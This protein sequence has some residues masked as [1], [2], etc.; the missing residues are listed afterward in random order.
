M[1]NIRPNALSLAV[2]VAISSFIIATDALASRRLQTKS[3]DFSGSEQVEFTQS[4]VIVTPTLDDNLQPIPKSFTTTYPDQTEIRAGYDIPSEGFTDVLSGIEGGVSSVDQFETDENNV[5]QKYTKVLKVGNE[6]VFRFT[7]N[8]AE[9]KLLIE[10][11]NSM[12]H[13]DSIGAV[14]AQSG[15]AWTLEPF[16]G[17]ASPDHLV[18]VLKGANERAGNLGEADNYIALAT[19]EVDKVEV[20]GRTF[21]RLVAAGDQPPELQRLGQSLFVND[22]VLLAAATSAYT[23]VHV[24]GKDIQQRALEDLLSYHNPVGYVVHVEDETQ[25]YPVPAGYPKLEVTETPGE[26]IVFHGQKQSPTDIALVQNLYGVSNWGTGYDN[27]D[28]AQVK[29]DKVKSYRY[30]IRS[31]QMTILED[32]AAKRHTGLNFVKE[33]G[34]KVYELAYFEGLQ[35]ALASAVSDGADEVEFTSEH[36]YF[37]S[38]L[39]TPTWVHIQLLRHFGFKPVL[40]NLLANGQ[41]VQDIHKALLFLTNSYVDSHIYPSDDSSGLGEDFT[42]R[43]IGDFVGQLLEMEN[44]LEKLR[45]IEA[46]LAKQSELTSRL[47]ASAA[48]GIGQNLRM[49]EL[50]QQLVDELA[51]IHGTV[52]ALVNQ[53]ETLQ[54]EADQIPLLK[55]QVH[56]ART[57]A[58]KARNAQT[59]TELGIEDWDDTQPL[60]EQARLISKKITEIFRLVAPTAQSQKQALEENLATIGA[61]LIVVPLNEDDL[62]AGQQAF[63]QQITSSEAKKAAEIKKRFT[64]IAAYLNIKDFDSNAD[65]DVQQEHLIQTLMKMV[66]QLNMEDY[67]T[68]LRKASLAAVLGI[69]LN[70]D[71]SLEDR[72]NLEL[73]VHDKLFELSKLENELE[74]IRTPG[75][76]KVMPEVF[77]TLLAVQSVFEKEHLREEN[78]VYYHRQVISEAIRIYIREARQQSDEEALAVLKSMEGI[79]SININE[80]DDKA[81]RLKR[82]L[83]RLDGGDISNHELDQMD[84]ILRWEGKR[85]DLMEDPEKDLE[86]SLVKMDLVLRSIRDWITFKVEESDQRARERQADYLIALEDKLNIDTHENPAAQE[87]GE[88]FFAKLASKLHIGFADDADLSDQKDTLRERLQELMEELEETYDDEGVKRVSNNKIA[89]QLNI[90]D[91]RDDAG[92]N[93]QKSLIREKLEQLDEEVFKVGQPDVNERIAAI[94]NELDRQMARLGSKPRYV[95]DRELATARRAVEEAESEPETANHNLDAIR[96]KQLVSLGSHTEFKDTS[97][98]DDTTLNQ[99]MK[100]YQTELG[101]SAGDEQT[102]KERVEDIINFLLECSVEIRDEIVEELRTKTN[103]DIRID[104]D[105]ASLEAAHYVIAIKDH[106]DTY[107]RD[108]TDQVDAGF[109]DKIQ[110]LIQKQAHPKAEIEASGADIERMKKVLKAA[111]EAV[112]NDGGPF[113]YTPKQAKVLDAIHTFTQQHLLKKQAL[114]AAMSLAESAVES[115]KTIPCL[116]TFDFNDEFAPIRLQALAGDELT[117]KQASWIVEVFKSLKTIFRDYPFEPA[118]HPFRNAIREAQIL[119]QRAR[120]EI[121]TASQQYDDEIRDIGSAGI[122]FVEH[123]PGDLKSFPEYFASHSAS[124]KKIMALLREG[125]ISKVELENYMKAVRGVDGYQTVAEFEHF[126]GY[127]HGVKVPEFRKVVQMLSDESAEAFMQSVFNPVTG[128]LMGPAGMKE[129]LVG[130]KDYAAAVIANYVLDDIA[131]ENGRRTAAFLINVQDTLTPYANA[132]SLSESDL[133]KAI[134][135]TLMQAHAA[136][137][138]WQ[139]KEYWVKPSAFLVQAV[140]WY[141]SS[142]KPL[143]TTHTVSQASTL[144]LSNMSLLYLLDLTNRGDYLHRMLTPFQ[145]WLERYRVDLDRTGQYAYHSGIEQISEVGGLA[146]SLGKAASSVILLKTGSALFAR[147]HNANPQRYRSIFR[148]VPEIVKSMGS[149]QGIQVPLLHRATPQKVKTLAAATAGL[150][151]GPVATVGAYAHGLISGFTYAQTF[152]LALASSLTFDFFMNDNK[153]LTQW[154]GGPLGRCLDKINRWR[155]LGETDDE[156]LQRTAIASPQGF[157]ETDEEYASRV[158]ANNTM[159]GW[160]RHENYLQ[161]RERRERTM[162]LFENGWEKYFRENV[163]KWSFSHAESIPYSYTLG[164]FYE[165]KAALTDHKDK[166][167]RN[168][169]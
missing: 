70:E 47:F 18:R 140:T 106:S 135:D 117:F 26:I 65:I 8:L 50:N 105:P 72:V 142:Y 127:K 147:Q 80:G 126:L 73:M 89:D 29:K 61:R 98:K 92:I 35:L 46:V 62:E 97:D 17:M 49:E 58:T 111:E 23:Q 83:S 112:K 161:F 3:V 155:G 2:A 11:R 45:T 86:W 25:A 101:L 95:L 123:L 30:I 59:A 6:G 93:E 128:T 115:G 82:V 31:R 107:A 55:K 134:H 42:A 28:T 57:D 41:F 108:A 66:E 68:G 164:A 110:Q 40:R 87:R 32:L 133:I 54:R 4:E 10:V 166:N 119:V 114:G 9:E 124:G 139:L 131:F 137:V 160:T 88:T 79:L 71:S 165:R 5:A 43:V 1:R 69:D 7:H 56:D 116:K 99:A 53:I 16:T 34:D 121:K 22:E 38:E 14:R 77:R 15:D 129:S 151:L 143:L 67:Y 122:H 109:G 148:L 158:K 76:P 74:D 157:S 169:L 118:E 104:G 36:V 141:L 162:K 152:G 51:K 125:L 153:I 48:Q 100:Q 103:L 21:M 52:D 39:T 138:E 145:H 78:D 156:Y 90:N 27:K 120:N 20:D 81:A 91:Y 75:H 63:Q 19:L 102:N 150:V 84:K 13:Q 163:P 94:E 132:V 154:L 44:E 24:L 12:T 60:E 130:M 159:Y 149:G 64:T 96:R 37:T 146:M 85:P 144:S 167:P 136:A 113:Q 33:D 168:E